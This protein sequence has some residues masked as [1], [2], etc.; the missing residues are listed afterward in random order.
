MQADLLGRLP[1]E[2]NARLARSVA[3]PIEPGEDASGQIGCR[4]QAGV[5]GDVRMLLDYGVT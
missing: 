4:L 5:E 3:E 1:L 2:A